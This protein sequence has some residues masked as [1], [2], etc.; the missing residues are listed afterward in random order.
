MAL[1]IWVAGEKVTADDLNGNFDIIDGA[2]AAIRVYNP[3]ANS[4]GSTTRFDI[5]NPAG[6]TFRYTFDGTGTDPSISAAT[7]PVGTIVQIYSGNF[8]SNNNGL[9]IVTGSGSNYFEV[10]NAAGVAENDKTLGALGFLNITN[11]T[12]TKPTGLVKLIVE[13]IGG[14]AG[15]GGTNPGVGN[16][17]S[18]GG[19][20]A[21]GYSKKIILAASLSATE[22]ISVGIPGVA[23]SSAPTQG[24]NGGG[25]AF[26]AH[27]SASGGS[28]SG[29]GGVV[30]G[31]AGGVGLNGDINSKGGGGGP[32]SPTVAGGGASPSGSGGTSHMGGG[33]NSVVNDSGASG[34]AYGGGASGGSQAGGSSSGGAGG[35][36]IVIV[37][38]YAK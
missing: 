23:G 8:N 32:G 13:V 24:G 11:Q 7:V 1:K 26:G 21:G 33:G 25:S 29:V 20:G 35:A 4:G 12:W 34:G 18:A 27:L 31:G 15:S 38:E 3:T 19:A 2:P 30:S 37:T 14:G 9:F 28:P 22:N 17:G 16:T 5:T 6:T 36:G 10:T